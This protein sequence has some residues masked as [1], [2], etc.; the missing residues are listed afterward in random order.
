MSPLSGVPRAPSDPGARLPPG[1][2]GVN[3]LSVHQA[4]SGHLF[5]LLRHPPIIAPIA[6]QRQVLLTEPLHTAE[7]CVKTFNQFS[8]FFSPLG[9][10]R[11]RRPDRGAEV[12]RGHSRPA[13]LSRKGAE[14]PNGP[15]QGVEGKGE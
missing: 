7:A 2:L 6:A 3:L 12:S 10:R 15:R 1:L 4:A 13:I 8:P 5:C 14:G 11:D 9:Q